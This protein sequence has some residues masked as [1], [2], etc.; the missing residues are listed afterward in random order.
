[1]KKL[2]LVP[3][4]DG[5]LTAV[6]N[7]S[8]IA[9]AGPMVH[10][11]ELSVSDLVD[12][13]EILGAFQRKSDARDAKVVV[14]RATGGGSVRSGAGVIH[15]V[16]ALAS[17]GA[18]V[19][20]TVDQLLN[21]YVRP[22]L[23]AMTKVA[24]PARYFGRDWISVDHR[25]SASV[26]FA[27]VASSGRTVIEVFVGADRSFAAGT[28]A[29]HLGK[30]P[31]ALNT[32]AKVPVTAERLRAALVSELA[33]RHGLES[34]ELSVPVIAPAPPLPEDP[35]WTAVLDDAIGPIGAGRDRA[36][37]FRVGGELMASTDAMTELESRVAT[38]LLD[39]GADAVRQEIDAIVE[40]IFGAPEVA[41]FGARTA[42]I[43]D[44]IVA[45]LD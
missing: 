42:S 2:G 33:E 31:I 12:D 35:P 38:A 18:M 19:P 32:L 17:P 45:A 43:R 4:H 41:L 40:G 25:P 16:L 34:V 24:A 1:M 14:K 29:S 6:A 27:H 36:G 10:S 28:R 37:S 23:A 15:A 26:S 13:G 5:S 22:F 11:I 7:A 30:E 3:A 44:V 21:R 20:A 8:R 39:G 9:L